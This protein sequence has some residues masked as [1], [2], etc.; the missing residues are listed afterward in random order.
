MNDE[1]TRLRAIRDAINEYYYHNTQA[2]LSKD[3]MEQLD[4]FNGRQA[5]KKALETAIQLTRKELR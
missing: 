3:A 2:A 1:L 4:A 5:A